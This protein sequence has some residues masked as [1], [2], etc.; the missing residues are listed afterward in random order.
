MLVKKGN[1]IGLLLNLIFFH[2]YQLGTG[3]LDSPPVLEFVLL[4]LKDKITIAFPHAT[5]LK[6]CRKEKAKNLCSPIPYCHFTEY[7]RLTISFIL[8]HLLWLYKKLS[9]NLMA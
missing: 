6:Q 3:R 5:K 9:Q 1:F 4:Y 8:L 7:E 2:H